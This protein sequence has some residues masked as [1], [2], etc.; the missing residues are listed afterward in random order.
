MSGSMPDP[1]VIVGAGQAGVALAAKLRTLGHDGRLIMIGAEP[2]GPYQ[3]PPLSKKYVSG[4][5]AVDRLLIRPQSWYA[6]QN[7]ELRLSASVT[8]IS[9]ADR[10]LK[11][12]DGATLRYDRLALTTGATPRG[13]PAEMGGSLAGVHTIR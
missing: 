2:V 3:R 4:E 13:L 11:L 1:I 10:S 5:L 7:V 12:A 6:E 8:S 9:P